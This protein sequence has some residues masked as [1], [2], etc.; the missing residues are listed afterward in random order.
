MNYVEIEVKWLHK[1]S[2]VG[3]SLIQ[4]SYKAKKSHR[5][6]PN[7]TDH[8]TTM[9]QLYKKTNKGNHGYIY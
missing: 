2:N 9:E 8:S 4:R 3:I 6:L 7:R 1:F 5:K